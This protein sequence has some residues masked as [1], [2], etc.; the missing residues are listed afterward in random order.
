MRFASAALQ[1]LAVLLCLACVADGAYAQGAGV[2]EP[3]REED[4]P[5]A[6]FEYRGVQVTISESCWKRRVGKQ[7]E[8]LVKGW[9]TDLRIGAVPG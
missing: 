9:S 2:G 1:L 3:C 7:C 5:P 6:T 8:E 4:D